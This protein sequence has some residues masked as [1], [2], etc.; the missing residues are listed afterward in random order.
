MESRMNALGKK[1]VSQDAV[2]QALETVATG[3][4]QQIVA[5]ETRVTQKISDAIAESEARTNAKIEGVEHRLDA[6]IDGVEQRL[7]AKIDG[8]EQRLDAKIDGVERRLEAKIDGVDAKVDALKQTTEE[9]FLELNRKLNLLL[10]RIPE[11]SGET[12]A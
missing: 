5:S 11:P 3:L 12:P 9:N 1:P 2:I 8:V 6:K 10:A 4:G 7:E